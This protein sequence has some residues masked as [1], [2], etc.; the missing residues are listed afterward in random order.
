MRFS[1]LLLCCLAAS[2]Q[3]QGLNLP[4]CLDLARQQSEQQLNLQHDCPALFKELEKQGLLASFDPPLTDK[5]SVNQLQLLADSRRQAP[6][7]GQLRREGLDELLANTLIVNDDAE[8]GWWQALLKWLDSLKPAEHEQQYQWLQRW[9]EALKP[10]QQTAEI[11]FYGSIALLLALSAWFVISEL[12][13]AGMLR[14]FWGGRRPATPA[15]DQPQLPSSSAH[16]AF[17]ALTP[18][19]Q[20]AGLLAQLIN[21]LA[22]RNLIPADPS[23][24]HRQLVSYLQNHGGQ[25][26]AAFS[27]LVHESEPWLYGN[28]AIDA[29]LLGG[30]RR[31]V[32][33][34]LA[35][36]P[37]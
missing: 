5:I 24:T 13:Q 16:P 20:I 25:V 33:A 18:H 27:H 23:L 17:S 7:S 32:Q 14:K 11:F 10:S 1:A 22:Q 2:S 35:K 21:A 3:A 31:E 28:R 30:Y 15:A 34:L 4:A 26:V 6:T 8:T 29:E 37:S 12:H 19:D 9:L 36:L